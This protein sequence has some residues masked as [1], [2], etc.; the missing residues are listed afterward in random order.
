MNKLLMI[1]LLMGSAAMADSN[2]CKPQTV[3]VCEDQR[4]IVI[5]KKK[6]KA[7]KPTPPK[8]I[9][10]EKE[11]IKEVTKKNTIMLFARKAFTGLDGKNTSS[12]NSTSATIYSN[13]G[14]TLGVQYI[15]HE[16]LDTPL[17]L[18]IGIDLQAMPMVS[19]GLDF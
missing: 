13:Y 8:E 2:M 18:G 14:L 4:V 3:N 15:R 19:A 16:I 11:V 1:L 6:R 7:A 12:A 5:D 10:V 17:A 9:I